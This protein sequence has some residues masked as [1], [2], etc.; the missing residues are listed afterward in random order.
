MP[1]FRAALPSVLRNLRHYNDKAALEAAVKYLHIDGKNQRDALYL[2]FQLKTMRL[3]ALIKC[4]YEL[5][6][7]FQSF[8]GLLNTVL[9][10]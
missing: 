10:R 2:S 3:L 4:L 6:M 9:F 5:R 8:I 7:I 1:I